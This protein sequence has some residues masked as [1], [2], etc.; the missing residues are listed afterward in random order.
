[1]KKYQI[2][3]EKN[4]PQKIFNFSKILSNT[5]E[6]AEVKMSI[7]KNIFKSG[8]ERALVVLASKTGARVSL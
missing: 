5:T 7:E 3:S 6:P 4:E 1:V 8:H 2:A